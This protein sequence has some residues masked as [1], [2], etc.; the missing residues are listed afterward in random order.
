MRYSDIPVI[1]PKPDD[2]NPLCRTCMKELADYWT[3]NWPTA[4]RL[5]ISRSHAGFGYFGNGFFCTLRCGYRYGL[6]QVRS[7]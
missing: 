2:E 7:N 5:P 6:R 1:T 3:L 4:S